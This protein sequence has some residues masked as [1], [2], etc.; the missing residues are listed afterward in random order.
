VGTALAREAAEQDRLVAT[1]DFAEGVR[2]MG[3]R[4]AP[5]FKGR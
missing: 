3:E 2:A 4:R 1:E 5:D